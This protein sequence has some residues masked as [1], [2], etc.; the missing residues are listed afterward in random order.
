MLKDEN[1]QATVEA[2]AELKRRADA[3][4]DFSEIRAAIDAE[5]RLR[6]EFITSYQALS[7]KDQLIVRRKAQLRPRKIQWLTDHTA[8]EEARK[9]WHGEI[10]ARGL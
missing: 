1:E 3:V 5:I 10:F 8:T 6:A 4:M 2:L 7:K 9:A